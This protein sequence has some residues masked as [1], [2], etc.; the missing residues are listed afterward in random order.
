VDCRSTNTCLIG[1][2]CQNG[3]CS[4]P[5]DIC[6]DNNACTEDCAGAPNCV[7]KPLDCTKGNKCI[8]PDCDP[9]GAGCKNTTRNCD[10]GNACSA[11]TCD[12]TTGC[13]NDTITCDDG[14][15]CTDDSCDP[16]SGCVFDKFNVTDRCFQGDIC[17]TF[18]CDPKTGC[19]ANPVN[20]P[21]TFNDSCVV[22][23]CDPFQGCIPAPY[24]CNATGKDAN[25]FI[26]YCNSSMPDDASKCYDQELDSCIIAKIAVTSASVLSVGA[27]VAIII[28][29][30]VCAAGTTV[31]AYIGFTRGFAGVFENKSGIYEAETI[32]GKNEAYGRDSVFNQKPVKPQ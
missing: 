11:D 6:N 22:A 24:I 20:C 18:T 1:S 27:I 21:N 7:F 32:Q 3:V 13:K 10:D 23:I 12:P 29:A 5:T 8:L 16:S 28:A 19:F 31:T 15:A 14:D 26:T 17:T 25:C 2:V 9:L 4:K 30:V